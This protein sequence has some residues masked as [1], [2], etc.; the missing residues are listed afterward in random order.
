MPGPSIPYQALGPCDVA[1]FL[2]DEVS[3]NVMRISQFIDASAAKDYAWQSNFSSGMR[4]FWEKK[5][6]DL[7]EWNPMV[8]MSEAAEEIIRDALSEETRPTKLNAHNA[9]ISTYDHSELAKIIKQ[10][11]QSKLPTA[12]VAEI[13]AHGS[14]LF[15]LTR[16]NL[17]LGSPIIALADYLERRNWKGCRWVQDRGGENFVIQDLDPI[18][19]KMREQMNRDRKN[20]RNELDSRNFK[21]SKHAPT[22][23]LPQLNLDWHKVE[24]ADSNVLAA[25]IKQIA[26]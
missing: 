2:I 7:F 9:Y 12:E 26:F 18:I 17:L 22:F 21:S 14:M 20:I 24:D 25:A 11:L 4:F 3:K 1:R 10:L 15:G 16:D 19:D 6:K 23:M 8:G 5:K 13:E